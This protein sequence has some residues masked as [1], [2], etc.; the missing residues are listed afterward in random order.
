M[1]CNPERDPCAPVEAVF[2]KIMK[3]WESKGF[4]LPLPLFH[5]EITSESSKVI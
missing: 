5:Q 3:D 1:M 2:G 4:P